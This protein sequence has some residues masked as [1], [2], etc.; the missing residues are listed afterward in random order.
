MEMTPETLATML[1][2]HPE[3]QRQLMP[4]LYE[5]MRKLLQLYARRY[6]QNHTTAC[7]AAGVTTDDL[8]SIAYFALVDAVRAYKPNR[9]E[10][11]SAYIS[12]HYKLHVAALMGYR[13][14]RR[15]ALNACI[16]LQ[17][18]TD[19]TGETTIEDIIPDNDSDFIGELL[20]GMNTEQACHEVR[21]AVERLPERQRHAVEQ[22]DLHGETLT[23]I[24]ANDG[25]SVECIRQAR[26]T[27]LAMLRRD[28]RLRLVYLECS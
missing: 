2:A 11:L 14:T 16:S 15:D 22:H 10:T 4:E 12:Y 1:Q 27:G 6:Y 25:V 13:T 8:T 19:E 26:R 17:T 3:R 23:A 24:A 7:N 18:P 21:K 28:S 9:P 5:R 20:D